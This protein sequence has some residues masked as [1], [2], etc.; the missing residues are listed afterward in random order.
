MTRKK[1]ISNADKS[2]VLFF[3][4]EAGLLIIYE[5]KP[6]LEECIERAGV[7]PDSYG[8][9][10]VSRLYNYIFSNIKDLKEEYDKYYS[11][12]YHS[13]KS[14]LYHKIVMCP[15]DIKCIEFAFSNKLFLGLRKEHI[16]GNDWA[17][18]DLIN[19]HRD[20]NIDEVLMTIL[21]ATWIQEDDNEN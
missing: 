19:V 21:N 2:Q 10:F 17:I 7:L 16:C 9:D 20:L 15:G 12:E 4:S 14:F 3:K 1:I 18:S 5:N 8:A 11:E 6:T 13:I